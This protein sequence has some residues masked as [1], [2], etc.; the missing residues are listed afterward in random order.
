LVQDGDASMRAARIA[1]M[2][3]FTARLSLI[4][5]NGRRD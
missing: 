1:R 2:P 4:G 5:K 3:H